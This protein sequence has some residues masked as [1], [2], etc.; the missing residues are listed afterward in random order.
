MRVPLRGPAGALEAVLWEPEAGGVRAA[1]AFGHPHPLRG[2][3]LDNTVVFRAARGLQ[4]AG[5]AVLRL[6]FRGVGESEGSYDGQR[7]GG[8][9]QD[10]AAAL[11]VLAERFPRTPLWAGGFSF[12]AWTAA[13]LAL[14]DARVRAL[15][16]VALPVAILPVD[17]L[18]DLPVG[19]AVLTAERDPFGGRAALLERLP[20]WAG[21]FAIEE[22]P[23]A[24]HFFTDHELAVEERVSTL[25]RQLIPEQR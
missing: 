25:A 18:A 15:L 8:E 5:V 4:R 12:G 11:D 22:V 20:G 10:L 19:G 2:G 21:R 24:D 1:C 13:G 6:N 7:A 9:E 23:D 17:D 16:L 14:H 3:S